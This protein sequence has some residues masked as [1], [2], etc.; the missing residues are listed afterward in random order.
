MVENGG[1]EPKIMFLSPIYNK[2]WPI[3]DFSRG[4][5]ATKIEKAQ[6]FLLE[7]DRNLILISIPNEHD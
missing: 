2:L 5:L 7:G 6:K 3:F 1:I 4:C